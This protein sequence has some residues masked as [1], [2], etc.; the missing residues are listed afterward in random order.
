MFLFLSLIDELHDVTYFLLLVE[1]F[2]KCWSVGVTSSD[3]F[4][5]AAVQRKLQRTFY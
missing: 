4:L 2:V 5:V 3:G 1:F